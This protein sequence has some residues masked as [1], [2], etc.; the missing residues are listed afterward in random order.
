MPGTQASN[1]NGIARTPVSAVVFLDILDEV[2]KLENHHGT[3]RI[4]G[5]HD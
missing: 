4:I 1:E 5:F 2:I 3:D